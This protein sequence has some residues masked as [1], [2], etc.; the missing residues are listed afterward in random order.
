MPRPIRA[1]IDLAALAHNFSLIKSKTASHTQIWA[2]VKA[3]AYGHGLWPVVET[4]KQADGFALIEIDSAIMLRKKG[5]QKPILLLEGFFDEKD[6][7]SALDYNLTPVICQPW[8]IDIFLSSLDGRKIP[9]Y[10][11]Y[12]TGMN[13][14]GIDHTMIDDALLRLKNAGCTVTLMTHFANADNALGIASAMDSMTPYLEKLPCCLANSAAILCSP[15][16][17]R[18]WIRP[19]ISLYGSSPVDHLLAEDIG[20]QP[21]MTLSADIIGIQSI[22]AGDAVGYGSRFTADAPMKIAIVACGYADGYPRSMPSGSPVLIDG[23]PSQ[24]LGRVSMDMLCVDITHL[25][26]AHI[27]S[28]VTLWG[29]GLSADRV[30]QCVDT[31]SYEL[32]CRI[33]ARVPFVYKHD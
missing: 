2:V 14:M 8:Q 16:T 20:L 18:N 6:C 31:I 22:H 24:T 15:E 26:D 1:T 5:I 19:G 11:K 32:F 23:Q 17:H 4:L 33:T 12:N 30:A 9:V 27:G 3:N 28:T 7:Q 10:L 29:K 13:R 21:V 25:P